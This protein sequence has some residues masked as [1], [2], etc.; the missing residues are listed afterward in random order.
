MR[1]EFGFNF[2]W[3]EGIRMEEIDNMYVSTSSYRTLLVPAPITDLSQTWWIACCGKRILFEKR[4]ITWSTERA[5]SPWWRF[6][7]SRRQKKWSSEKEMQQRCRLKWKAGLTFTRCVGRKQ[8][9]SFSLFLSLHRGG[10]KSLQQIWSFHRFLSLRKFPVH[11]RW[12]VVWSTNQRSKYPGNK[13]KA[14]LA[15]IRPSRS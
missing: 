2:A 3:I 4:H 6:L 12:S 13:V 15:T 7:N 11:S 1:N 8:T 9:L 14:S 5:S 10:S